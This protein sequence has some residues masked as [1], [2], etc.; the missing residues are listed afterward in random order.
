MKEYTLKQQQ[1]NR[2]RWV[3]ALRSGKYSQS[4]AYLKTSDGLCCL[5][6]LCEV[7]KVPRVKGDRCGTCDYEK[8]HCDC[9]HF[10]KVWKYGVDA[11]ACGCPVEAR[12]AVGLNSDTGVMNVSIEETN[13]LVGLNDTVQ[14]TFLQIADIIESEPEGLFINGDNNES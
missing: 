4:T 8:G 7:V 9:E 2:K 11:E 5:G 3:K 10:T 1:K 6:V 13:S 12:R 14:K